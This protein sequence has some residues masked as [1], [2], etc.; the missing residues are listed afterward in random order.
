[1]KMS[2]YEY[3]EER[4]MKLIRQDERELGIEQ[5]IEIGRG[6]GIEIG[7]GQGIEIGRGQGVVSSIR[8]LIQNTKVSMLDAMKMLG[9]PEEDKEKY[10]KMMEKQ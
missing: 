1:I 6:Q 3:D 5:G 7:R 9:I 8:N 10:M 2:I 4:E